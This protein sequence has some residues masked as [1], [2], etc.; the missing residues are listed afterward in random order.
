MRETLNYPPPPPPG[1][2]FPVPFLGLTVQPC[3]EPCGSAAGFDFL[4]VEVIQ[5]KKKTHSSQCLNLCQWLVACSRPGRFGSK[6]VCK[7][8]NNN[9]RRTE[10]DGGG[11]GE[12]VRGYLA[13]RKPYR[14]PKDTKRQAWTSQGVFSILQ[15]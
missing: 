12:A 9:R 11:G 3:G 2:H 8:T 5:M 1:K 15:W 10:L 4:T 14:V 13:S 6:N 7:K